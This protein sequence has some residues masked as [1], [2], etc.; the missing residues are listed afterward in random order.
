MTSG[1]KRAREEDAED[2]DGV[3]PLADGEDKGY[4]ED[5]EERAGA[6]KVKTD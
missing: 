3:G 6:K 5:V 1:I 2:E 4:E